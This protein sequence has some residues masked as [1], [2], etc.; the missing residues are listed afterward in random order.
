MPEPGTIAAV[1]AKWGPWLGESAGKAIVGEIYKSLFFGSDKKKLKAAL[2][3]ISRSLARIEKQLDQVYVLVEEI[4]KSVEEVKKITLQIPDLGN[5]KEA[6]ATFSAILGRS[7]L[8]IDA[9]YFDDG[10]SSKDTTVLKLSF[11]ELRTAREVYISQRRQLDI[12]LHSS[13]P[14]I[15]VFFYSDLQITLAFVRAIWGDGNDY[16]EALRS[17]LSELM[18]TYEP[19]LLAISNSEGNGS[20]DI[21]LEQLNNG[22][23]SIE[24]WLRPRETESLLTISMMFSGYY[25]SKTSEGEVTLANWQETKAATVAK[26]TIDE[27]ALGQRPLIGVDWLQYVHAERD[28]NVR[29]GTTTEG[30]WMI[31]AQSRLSPSDSQFKVTD[32]PKPELDRFLGLFR[33]ISK[34]PSHGV[35]LNA[36]TEF[37]LKVERHNADS[38]MAA[39][40]EDLKLKVGDALAKIS[41]SDLP[42]VNQVRRLRTVSKQ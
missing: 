38:S 37:L 32:L 24:P 11:E 26:K 27:V 25:E 10:N 16:E 19:I 3:E 4:R 31:L 13:A 7:S 35:Q 8:S 21:H 17:F 9:E 42:L 18:D 34:A 28:V 2:A 14:D 30:E 15:L 6:H 39:M 33:P 1:V 12:A 41:G 22:L 36:S 23:A 40:L 20:L 29:S 5:T